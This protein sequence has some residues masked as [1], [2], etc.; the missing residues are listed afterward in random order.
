MK[1]EPDVEKYFVA[2]LLHDIGRLVMCLKI[3]DQ[4][5]I[6][7]DFAPKSGNYWYK[8]EAKYFGFDHGGVGGSLLRSW[9]LTGWLQESVA[10]NHNP[11]AVKNYGHEGAVIFLPIISAT[12]SLMI[13]V[14]NI[15]GV[16]LV[17]LHGKG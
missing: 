10:H 11:S 9:N 14:M 6:A 2:G 4:F 7:M 17:L 15:L 8:A 12:K 13:R 16:K 5:R 3:P 1:N